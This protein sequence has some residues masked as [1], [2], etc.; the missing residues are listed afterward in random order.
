M[1]PNETRPAASPWV[2]FL[3]A[4][5]LSGGALWL[6]GQLHRTAFR[7]AER[8]RPVYYGPVFHGKP[9]EHKLARVGDKRVRAT[10]KNAPPFI[11]GLEQAPLEREPMLN[12]GTWLVMAFGF[13]STSDF[14]CIDLAVQCALNLADKGKPIQLGVRPFWRY[15]EMGTWLGAEYNNCSSPVWAVYQDGVLLGMETGLFF[16]GDEPFSL[17]MLQRWVEATLKR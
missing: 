10:F 13:F 2:V 17:F 7:S 12:R 16:E 14:V 3:L 15:E 5:P 9:V 6:V 8:T 11:H 1:A 4:L